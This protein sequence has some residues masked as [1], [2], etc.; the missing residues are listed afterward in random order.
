MKIGERYPP[1]VVGSMII[2]TMD[3]RDRAYIE[4]RRGTDVVQC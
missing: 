1:L 2:L 4:Y 3:V